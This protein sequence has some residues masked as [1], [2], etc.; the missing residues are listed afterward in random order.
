MLQLLLA[1]VY[2][3]LSKPTNFLKY[4]ILILKSNPKSI[5]K[6]NLLFSPKSHFRSKS[7][8][9]TFSFKSTFFHSNLSI[10]SPKPN[11]TN[12]KTQLL[13]FQLAQDPAFEFLANPKPNKFSNK[14]YP[15]PAIW[16]YTMRERERERER[17][18]D[19]ISGLGARIN[20]ETDRERKR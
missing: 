2:L 8:P 9:W 17:E 1:K 14:S 3:I 20:H 7:L 12:I 19:Q 5:P 15:K 13:F 16:D 11:F 18:R 10:K 6:S 4:W